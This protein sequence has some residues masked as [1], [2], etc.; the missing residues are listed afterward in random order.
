MAFFSTGAFWLIIIG[1]IM[2]IVAFGIFAFNRSQAQPTS[3]FVWISGALGAIL[4]IGGLVW[5]LFGGRRAVV[6]T[7]FTPTTV[8]A[9]ATVPG[10][11]IPR[12]PYTSPYLGPRTY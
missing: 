6:A 4:L 10:T 8:V 12:S 2:L 7:T 1:I 5:W 3:T 9:P 11:S